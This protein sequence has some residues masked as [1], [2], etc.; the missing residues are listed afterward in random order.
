MRKTQRILKSKRLTKAKENT[1]KSVERENT[2]SKPE[3]SPVEDENVIK[4]KS[5]CYKCKICSKSCSTKYY[6]QQ[7]LKSKICHKCTCS[8][9][10]KVFNNKHQLRGHVRLHLGPFPCNICAREFYSKSGCDRH[11]K[12]VHHG[13]AAYKC[14][15]C[16]RL[17]KT[18][19]GLKLHI[20]T[21][22]YTGEKPF[23]CNDCGR[24]FSEES[25]LKKHMIIHAKRELFSCSV[26]SKQ[27]SRKS[28]LKTHMSLHS[29]EKQNKC[30]NVKGFT[31]S[32]HMK[33]KM[34]S[35]QSH[36]TNRP[37]VCANC[38]KS[39]LRKDQW[40]GHSRKCHLKNIT[41]EP[42]DI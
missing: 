38:G 19:E 28:T 16:S 7:H 8:I 37:F 35:E 17:F 25:Y 10:N 22:L 31:M 4:T 36:S 3:A 6:L 26:C 32:D 30:M 23:K 1:P 15:I 11:I 29:K 24:A 33:T 21:H 13:V 34:T 14:D 27:F 2:L 39:F 18:N 41:Q 12:R 40:K 42:R 5:G 20:R 9:C